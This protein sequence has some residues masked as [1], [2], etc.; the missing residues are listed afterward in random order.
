MHLTAA[1]AGT[2]TTAAAGTLTTAAAGTLT[3]AAAGTLT[4]AMLVHV[5]VYL[6]YESRAVFCVV[7]VVVARTLC[8]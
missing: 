7:F 1:V 5:H 4:A 3:T 6:K 2:L 8:T